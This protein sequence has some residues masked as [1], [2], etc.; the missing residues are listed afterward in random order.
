MVR[1]DDFYSSI[2][3]EAERVAHTT[4][5][6]TSG[7]LGNLEP[8]FL[9]QMHKAMNG[10]GE[11]IDDDSGLNIS[12]ENVEDNVRC[13]WPSIETACQFDFF[14]LGVLRCMPERHVYAIPEK[15]RHKIFHDA[16]PNPCTRTSFSGRYAAPEQ[17]N[18]VAEKWNVVTHGKFMYN[19]SGGEF[20]GDKLLLFFF[21]LKIPFS[22]INTSN[23][24]L[25]LQTKFSTLARTISAKRLGGYAISSLKM[26]SLA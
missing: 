11:C 2:K 1:F 20:V 26:S 9:W 6:A 14:G 23:P 15:S 7:S 4:L 22:T 13:L 12:W 24:I 18:E 3:Y 10:I 5:Y 17:E 8:G 21:A 16:R 25:H 19:D